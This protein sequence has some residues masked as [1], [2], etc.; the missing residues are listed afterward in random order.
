MECSFSIAYVL[1]NGADT[2]Q[3]RF[4]SIYLGSTSSPIFRDI[5][6]PLDRFVVNG[7]IKLWL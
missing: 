7:G 3:I 4:D 2:R 6:A 1:G 5:Y